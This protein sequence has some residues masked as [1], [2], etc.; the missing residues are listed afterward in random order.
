MSDAEQRIFE[1]SL[2]LAQRA[3]GAGAVVAEHGVTVPDRH[4]TP[5]I[6]SSAELEIRSRTASAR[7]LAGPKLVLEDDDG[8]T[9]GTH[10]HRSGGKTGP[11]PLKSR[12]R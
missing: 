5:K 6:D 9:L 7:L 11:R 12:S 1:D 8:P 4:G 3:N 2:R 10:A